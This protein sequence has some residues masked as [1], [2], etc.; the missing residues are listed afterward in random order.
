MDKIDFSKYSYI[1][2]EVS[3]ILNTTTLSI[4]NWK[5]LALLAAL[6]IGLFLVPVLRFVFNKIKMSHKFYRQ[7]PRS[8]MGYLF[9]EPVQKPLAWI[10]VIFLY[11]LAGD[12]LE[13][14]GRFETFYNNIL[15][16]C[17]AIQVI[18]LIYYFVDAGG[19][20]LHDIAVSRQTNYDNQLIP[21]A[22]KCAKI[23]IVFLGT[24]LA[25]QSFGINVVSILAGL[26]LGGLA[27]ALAAQDTAANLFGSITIFLD[28]PFK[29][30]DLIKVRDIE[31]TVES[32]G[33]R[34]TRLR[35]GYNSLITVPN[36]VMAKENIDNMGVRNR[37]RSRQIIGLT[38]ETP[39]EKIEA[40]CQQVQSLLKGHD[41]VHP[42]TI[43]V[44]FNNFNQSSLDV[45]VNFHLM[46]GTIQEELRLQQEIFLDILKIAK[47]LE[48]DI[49]YQ[50]QMVYQKNL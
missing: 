42:D 5:W 27:L 16:A 6:L 12:A 17:M 1:S 49:A 48:A 46:V 34:S 21:F 41:K 4:E 23:A 7:E 33:F 11:F 26:G 31:G 28:Q 39:P 22:T 30:N 20:T 13:I 37:R 14:T 19:S 3:E 40:F 18:K 10:V 45:L 29:V 36:S 43:N 35:T 15:R 50:T 24:L 9:L 38:Y 8:F 47:A 2:E 32:I 44:A 25:L